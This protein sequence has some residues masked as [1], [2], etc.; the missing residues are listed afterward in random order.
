MHTVSV[1][2]PMDVLSI[3]LSESAIV[4]K[5]GEKKKIDVTIVRAEEFKQNITLDLLYRHLGGVFGD[6]LPKGVT[7]DEKASQ[8]LLTGGQNTGSI[9]LVA[10]ADAK[11][12]EK[13]QVAVMANVSL[14]FVMKMTY[15]SE[16]LT[17]TVAA[18]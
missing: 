11:P 5:P 1:G 15:S 7:I 14:N 3:K 13:Q 18:P 4:L 12:V 9:T 2:D 8:T 17:V 6:S 10:A 16:P